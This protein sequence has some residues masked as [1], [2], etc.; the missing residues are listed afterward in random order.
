MPDFKDR[1]ESARHESIFC[2]QY[3]D[4]MGCTG[5]LGDPSKD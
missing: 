4:D 5:F 3:Y 2:G 1:P